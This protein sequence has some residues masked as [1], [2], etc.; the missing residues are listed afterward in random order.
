[1]KAMWKIGRGINC[2]KQY[3]SLNAVMYASEACL[4][5]G[6]FVV[7]INVSDEVFDLVFAIG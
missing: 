3:K 6:L 5:F 4:K 2:K 1:M 7:S